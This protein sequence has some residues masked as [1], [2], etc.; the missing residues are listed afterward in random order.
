MHACCLLSASRHHPPPCPPAA[1]AARS[2]SLPV[3]PGRAVRLVAITIRPAAITV[4]PVAPFARS[5]P[6]RWVFRAGAAR[7]PAV[8]AACHG[9]RSV[10][11]TPLRRRRSSRL[12][13]LPSN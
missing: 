13:T 5:R 1:A 11:L 8:D 10:P 12:L 6:S 7:M 9:G 3:W 2:S 4:R